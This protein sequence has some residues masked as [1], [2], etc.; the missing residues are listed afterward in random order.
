[1][2]G[3]GWVRIDLG[4]GGDPAN[5]DLSA[6]PEI[7]EVEEMGDF[8]EPDSERYKQQ[9]EAYGERMA[10]ALEK[11]G[12]TGE[13]P[14]R[15]RGGIKGEGEIVRPPSSITAD[16]EKLLSLAPNLVVRFLEIFAGT[17][18]E[19]KEYSD[20]G[21]QIDI[22]KMITGDLEPFFT[23]RTVEALASLRCG[24][25]IDQSG[26][27]RG[28][29]LDNFVMMARFYSSL[30]YYSCV[31]NK[32][33]DF[34]ISTVGDHYHP[35]LDCSECR[36]KDRVEYAIGMIK[37]IKDNGG[38]NT[39][40]II[41]GVRGKYK[42]IKTK[43]H[44]L[45]IVLTDGLETSRETFENLKTK[46]GALETELNLDM[47]FIG[48][49][50]DDVKNYSKYLVLDH[51]PTTDE[52]IQIIM[53]LALLKVSRGMLP[54][55]DLKEFLSLPPGTDDP[56]AKPGASP[57]VA[58]LNLKTGPN[59]LFIVPKPIMPGDSRR[60]L[61]FDFDPILAGGR[62]A[63]AKGLILIPAPLREQIKHCQAIIARAGISQ[64]SV[65][66]PLGEHTET[67][68]AVHAAINS[69]A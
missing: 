2:R 60:L 31:R 61:P 57:T 9:A 51:T 49:E 43:E 45:E 54:Q 58:P 66:A 35:L 3:Y 6:M 30:F 67:I 4:G 50:T 42:S 18:K 33:V 40:S 46:V 63:Q 55:G 15:S 32:E 12:I 26:S 19:M 62:T 34:S 64:R 5:Y 47:V 14:S 38:I 53:K 37:N 17:P 36:Y 48:I 21:D 16:I 10:E 24:L 27:T 23:K 29:L 25:T 1:M 22:E 44:N 7:E 69:G 20:T 11:A 68:E 65:P 39:L 28:E 59:D 56:A 13:A 52:L 41:K 8:P